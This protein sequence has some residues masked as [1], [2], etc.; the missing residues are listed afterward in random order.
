MIEDNPDEIDDSRRRAL[1]RKYEQ[2]KEKLEEEEKPIY[3]G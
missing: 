3:V 1:Q 2:E